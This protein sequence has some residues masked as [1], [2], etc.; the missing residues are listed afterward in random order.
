[1][2]KIKI[3]G[4]RINEFYLISTQHCD[5]CNEILKTVKTTNSVKTVKK[6]KIK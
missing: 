3:K 2:V 4:I 6:Q 5:C 1:M